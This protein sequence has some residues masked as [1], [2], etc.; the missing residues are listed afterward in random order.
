MITDQGLSPERDTPSAPPHLRQ[1]QAALMLGSGRGAPIPLPR[2]RL[3]RVAATMPGV[4]DL[5][6]TYRCVDDRLRD[7][8]PRTL[9][10][11]DVRGFGGTATWPSRRSPSTGPP[12]AAG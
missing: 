7:T 6:P 3:R 4:H 2:R 5:L 1:S 11:E 12:P 10:P 8:D 9:T